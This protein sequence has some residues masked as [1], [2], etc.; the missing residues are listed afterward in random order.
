MVTRYGLRSSRRESDKNSRLIAKPVAEIV[1]GRLGR[2][3]VVATE[4]RTPE[5]A[6]ALLV[7][8]AATV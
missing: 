7:A 4:R 3:H 6:G 2:T 8:W 5:R 1:A